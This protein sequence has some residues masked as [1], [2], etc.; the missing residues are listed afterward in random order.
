[1]KKIICMLLIFS[2]VLVSFASCVAN[3]D[4]KMAEEIFW[5]IDGK[6]ENK[7]YQE[8]YEQLNQFLTSEKSDEIINE[9][10]SSVFENASQQESYACIY[11]SYDATLLYLGKYD[12]FKSSVNQNIDKYSGEQYVYSNYFWMALINEIEKFQ[13]LDIDKIQ[14][15][16][17]EIN[18]EESEKQEHWNTLLYYWSLYWNLEISEDLK[19][20]VT[21]LRLYESYRMGYV[22]PFLYFN[23]NE[24]FN[25]LFV[26]EYQKDPF[27]GVDI[28]YLI[29]Q[30]NL[31]E[32]QL[33]MLDTSLENLEEAYRANRPKVYS[34][35][36]EIIDNLQTTIKN[37]K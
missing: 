7:D 21:H 4:K 33:T 2:L 6:T 12:E 22:V 36:K 26:E 14:K 34:L 37:I 10:Y 24:D 30:D 20:E 17:S 8:I 16:F 25:R 15:T 18:F 19:N 29:Q 3:E 5:I 1:M 27:T 13:K 32:E 11:G 31:T 35:K 28:M 9:Y 23:K